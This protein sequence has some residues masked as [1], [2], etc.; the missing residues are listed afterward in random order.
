MG[1]H[2]RILNTYRTALAALLGT[3]RVDATSLLHLCR[4]NG[5]FH[6]NSSAVQL[7]AIISYVAHLVA[8]IGGWSLR[9]DA[10]PF[11]NINFAFIIVKESVL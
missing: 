5:A 11:D 4:T 10:N 9:I 7:N 3:R 8:S 2:W 1:A 6:F